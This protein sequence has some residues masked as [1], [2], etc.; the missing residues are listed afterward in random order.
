MNSS[1]KDRER[2]REEVEVTPFVAEDAE[3]LSALIG[4]MDDGAS[5]AEGI[6][7]GSAA[8]Y[9]WMYLENPAGPAI[10][11]VARHEGKVIGSFAIAPKRFSIAGEPVLVGK[12]MDMFTDPLYQGLGLMG[13]LARG[14]FEEAHAAGLDTWYVT[15]SPNSYPIFLKKWGYRETHE[16]HFACRILRPSGLLAAA[17]KAQTLARWIGPPLDELWAIGRAGIGKGREG[18]VFT[19]LERFDE[20]TDALWAQSD[21][22]DVCLVRDAWYLNW[23]FLDGPDRYEV[24]RCDRGS[25]LVGWIVLKRTTRR[26]QPCGDI[27]D[28]L[29][30][31]GESE[32]PR[33]MLRWAI[34]RFAEE[35]CIMAQAWSLTGAPLTDALRAA[36]LRWN[37]A[38]VPILFTPDSPHE[39]IYEPARWTLTLGDGNDV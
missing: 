1:V 23:R 18:Y 9:R 21:H 27:V 16:L 20:E 12:T 24:F 26:G 3:G 11:H 5:E 31:K 29:W 17:G 39:A 15:P 36:G 13:R 22:G 38:R 35:G 7:D 4:G 34:E 30:R 19:E 6:R 28:L 33:V 14:V 25:K 2:L 32:A 37:R 8:Y 10:V